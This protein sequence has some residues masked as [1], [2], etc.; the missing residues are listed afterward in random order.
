MKTL[1]DYFTDWEGH[2]FGSGYGTGEP[3][4][5]EALIVFLRRCYGG[6][7]HNMYNHVELE[8]ALGGATTW[9]LISA[10]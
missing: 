2:V 9:L 4:V 3:Y 6:T 1:E 8:K 5:L 10:L 7:Y